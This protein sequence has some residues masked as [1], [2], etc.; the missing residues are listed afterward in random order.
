MIHLKNQDLGRTQ[1]PLHPGKLPES[2][3]ELREQWV[4][5]L[6]L[7]YTRTIKHRIEARAHGETQTLLVGA[8]EGQHVILLYFAVLLVQFVDFAET[9]M[10]L[11]FEADLDAIL[12][13]SHITLKIPLFVVDAVTERAA[14]RY[15]V[16]LP[17][18][19][20]EVIAQN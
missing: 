6:E 3:F 9:L 14:T 8:N 18:A 5:I 12:L 20:S 4:S 10:V 7:V 1:E 2:T 11:H 15:A 17:S 19:L 13:G 16:C